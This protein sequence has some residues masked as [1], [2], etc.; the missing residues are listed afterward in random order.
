MYKVT[1]VGDV[2][3]GPLVN[4]SRDRVTNWNET[5]RYRDN[6]SDFTTKI[7][8]NS[9]QLSGDVIF[10]H[11]CSNLSLLTTFFILDFKEENNEYFNVS[12]QDEMCM[13]YLTFSIVL[14]KGHKLI[15]FFV[16]N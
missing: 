3:N 15:F 5:I 9:R 4:H 7:D 1:Q 13:A 8:L 14:Y 12:N 10:Y 2:A 6:A 16:H 11:F